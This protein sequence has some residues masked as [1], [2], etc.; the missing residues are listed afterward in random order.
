MMVDSSETFQMGRVIGR[1][2]GVISRNLVVFLAVSALL[3]VPMVLITGA[4]SQQSAA[5]QSNDPAVIAQN[6]GG[7]FGVLMATLLVQ[8][9]LYYMLQACL[10][11]ATIADLRGEK[12][13]VV[14]TLLA[15]LQIVL[16][17]TIISVLALLGV[18]AGFLLL[19]IP[20]IILLLWWSIIS[21]VRVVENTGIAETFGRSR[22]L[23]RGYRWHILGL[24]LLFVVVLLLATFAV[25][26]VMGLSL[27]EDNP[28]KALSMSALIANGV[29]Q[30]PLY[31]ILA[32]GMASIYYEL[33]LVKEGLGPQQ[34]ASA[35]D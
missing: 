28:A 16:P 2:F 34:L 31:G 13:Q 6:I 22:A 19:I 20:G 1:T 12:P 9:V 15:G 23:T 25:H 11:H 24:L 7:I 32:V 30:V 5:L 26:L 29:V 35:F 10:A 27:V 17:V 14:P 33:R 4:F 18:M 21:P 3:M 8:T